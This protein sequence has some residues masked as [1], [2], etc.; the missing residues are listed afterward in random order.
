MNANSGNTCPKRKILQMVHFYIGNMPEDGYRP[1]TK[2]QLKLGP[3]L[4]FQNRKI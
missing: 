4:H 1:V 2:I 3:N